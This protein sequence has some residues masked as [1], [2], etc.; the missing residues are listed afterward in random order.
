MLRASRAG[1][2]RR[3]SAA[4]GGE[5]P[6]LRSLRCGGD[7]RAGAGARR[8]VGCRPFRASGGVVRLSGARPG[9]SGAAR[10]YRKLDHSLRSLCCALIAA[11]APPLLRSALLFPPPSP[12]SFLFSTM[13]FFSASLRLCF[14]FFSPCSHS[15]ASRRAV[16]SVSGMRRFAASPR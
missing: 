2:W 5:T 9:D 14:F 11:P 3:W 7:P 1:I 15:F 4:H 13:F 8:A 12:S 6:S 16:C 10:P